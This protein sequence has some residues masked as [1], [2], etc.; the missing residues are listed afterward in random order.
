MIAI[1]EKGSK[2]LIG[3]LFVPAAYVA[4]AVL[5]RSVESAPFFSGGGAY[6]AGGVFCYFVLHTLVWEPTWFYVLGHELTHAFFG[7]LFRAKVS[8]VEIS[9]AGGTTTLS[10]SNFLISLGPY[11]VPF[12]TLIFMVAFLVL[13]MTGHAAYFVKPFL[14][15][16]GFT[17]AMHLVMT[18]KFIRMDQPDIIR[19]GQLF[20]LV[21]IA[22]VNIVMLAGVLSVAVPQLEFKAYVWESAL[23]IRQAYQSIFKQLFF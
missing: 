14:A 1:L 15:A 13:R 9:A 20:S 7:L 5:W 6:F 8:R 12:Y 18:V 22:L 19:T 11:L 4:G 21:V 17:W 23:R 10:K 2:F 3:V 16:I